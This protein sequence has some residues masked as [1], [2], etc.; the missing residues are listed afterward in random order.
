MN[1]IAD[2]Q[3]ICNVLIQEAEKDRDIVVACSDS[4]GSGSMT[5]FADAFPKQFVEVGI[6]EQSPFPSARGLRCAAK[7]V[8]GVAGVVP[9]HAQHGTGQGGCRL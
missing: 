7:G 4:R 9:F 2:K 3:V 1:R 6:A 5:A 8:R